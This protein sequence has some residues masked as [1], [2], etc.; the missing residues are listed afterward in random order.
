MARFLLV[1]FLLSSSAFGLSSK[2][3]RTKAPRPR[4]A[5]LEYRDDWVAI[6][7]PAGMSVHRS[8]RNGGHAYV[9]STLLKRQLRRKVFPVHRLDHRTSGC[10]LFAFSPEACAELQASLSRST[11]RYAMLTRG[12]WML[13]KETLVDSPIVVDGRSKASRTRFRCLAS[14]SEPRASLLVAEPETGR[15]HQIRKHAAR[16]NNPILGD[17]E[18]GDS[19]ANRWWR[20][21]K[22][23]DRLAL[24]CLTLDLKGKG[25]GAAQEENLTITA[26][27][28]ADLR[29]VL[30]GEDRLWRPA[31]DLEPA[32]ALDPIDKRDGSLGPLA[33]R[34]G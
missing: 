30:Q 13:E 8:Q 32:L 11:K 27:L 4:L 3:P 34:K 16:S 24:H 20:Q 33:A 23:L 7:K 9:V 14:Q 6:N 25:K 29:S 15:T 31:L 2:T 22:G 1:L 5:V 18:H 28:P 19:A 26:P 17:T 10:L 21:N 12:E